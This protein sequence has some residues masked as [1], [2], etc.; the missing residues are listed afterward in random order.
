MTDKLP[1][2][3]ITEDEAGRALEW[4]L[5]N[6]QAI[7]DAKRRTVLAE[8]SIKRVMAIAMKQ[9]NEKSAAA[10]ERDALAGSSYEA[11]IQEEADAAAGYELL[12]HYKDTAFA[13]L[14]AWRTM[15][16]TRRSLA[17]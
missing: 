13:R 5:K 10:Q 1:A 7:A 2:A 6:G 17:K 3:Y 4:L 14:D 12:R 16:S 9:S 15:E 11:A 8:R